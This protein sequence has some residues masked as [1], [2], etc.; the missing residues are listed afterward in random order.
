[1]NENSLRLFSK[2]K[3][4]YADVLNAI[5]EQMPEIDQ[6]RYSKAIFKLKD[7]RTLTFGLSSYDRSITVRDTKWNDELRKF[8][9]TEFYYEPLRENNDLLRVEIKKEKEEDDIDFVIRDDDYTDRYLLSDEE[10]QE[11]EAYIDELHSLVKTMEY[12][13]EKVRTANNLNG[14]AGLKRKL[15]ILEEEKAKLQPG[16][17]LPVVKVAVDWWIDKMTG[18]HRCANIGMDGMAGAFASLFMQMAYDQDKPLP[19][20]MQNFEKILTETITKRLFEGRDTQLDVDYGPSG[21]LRDVLIESHVSGSRVPLKT[22][23]DISF[24]RVTVSCGYA[25]PWETIYEKEYEIDKY[26]DE[27][28]QGSKRALKPG[29]KE[30]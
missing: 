28:E 25:A 5:D 10:Y 27:P 21:V 14:D 29:Q 17:T 15:A 12:V 23:M 6:K 3:E 9:G 26:L 16:E 18:S 8:V 19:E 24:D 22:T 13:P 11:T 7:G 20:E 2:G 30:S 4:I 1:M